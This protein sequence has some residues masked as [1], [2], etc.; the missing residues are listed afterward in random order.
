MFVCHFGDEF[1]HCVYILLDIQH[2][3]RFLY[4]DADGVA[5]VAT[6]RVVQ[7]EKMGKIREQGK[8]EQASDVDRALRTSTAVPRM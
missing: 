8:N 4:E 6:V 7:G 1:V 3:S 5:E 2:K